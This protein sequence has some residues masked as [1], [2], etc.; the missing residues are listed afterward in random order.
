MNFSQPSATPTTGYDEDANHRQLFGWQLTTVRLIWGTFAVITVGLFLT[1]IPYRFNE[2]QVLCDQDIPCRNLQI[3]PQHEPL[4][5]DSGLSLNFYAGTI[6]I[7]ETA[8]FV[9][10]TAVALVIVWRKSDDWFIFLISLMLLIAPGGLT[11]MFGALVDHVPELDWLKGFWTS[12]A[13]S[14]GFFMIFALPDGRFVPRWSWKVCVAWA[15]YAMLLIPSVVPRFSTLADIL[16]F[17]MIFFGILSQV[18]RYKRIS[19]S[20]LQQQTKWI[21]YGFVISV[22]GI[23]LYQMVTQFFKMGAN[24]QW[25]PLYDL[26]AYP[27]RAISVFSFLVAVG[28]SVLRYRL[29]EIDILINRTLIYSI[30]TGVLSLVYLGIIAFFQLT[31][32]NLINLSNEIAAVAS[33]LVIITLFQPVRQQVQTAVDRR[34]YRRKYDTAQTLAAFSATLRD[35]VNLTDLLQAISDVIQETMQPAHLTVWLRHQVDRPGPEPFVSQTT[36]ATIAPDDPLLSHCQ[37]ANAT[38]VL[39][40]LTFQSPALRM[41]KT[42]ATTILVPIIN[43]GELISIVAL[44]PRLS[45]QAYTFDDRKLL[46]ELAIQVAPAIR[47]A[48]LVHLEQESHTAQQIQLNLLPH[49]IPQPANWHIDTYYQPART[50]GG[51]YYDF[52]ELPDG[53]LGF[54]IA[55]ATGKGMAAALLMATSRSILRAAGRRLINPGAVLAEANNLI[56]A[57]I[58]EAMFVTCFYAILNPANGELRF[59][60][61]GHNLPYRWASSKVATLRATGLPLGLMP[62]RA[63]QEHRTILAPGDTLLFYTDGL[64]EAH[65]R[66]HQ[67]FGPNR[68]QT[69]LAHVSDGRTL[70]PHLVDAFTSFARPDLAQ[71][72]DMTLVTFTHLRNDSDHPQSEFI[73]EEPT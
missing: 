6:T 57:D 3:S 45:G 43:Q 71:F 18:Y 29:W 36:S 56:C 19:T 41:M 2:L 22:L 1:A 59:A 60:N 70:I 4:L 23:G 17:S 32:S 54:M 37:Q 35:Q 8:V 40:R 10:F 66:D 72:D 51:D 28:I 21:M 5:A 15:I 24:S 65:N 49:V 62:A 64:V 69:L 58:P 46:Y 33:I 67:M 53:R 11:W 20:I 14:T 47:V 63:Y 55:D 27:M 44:G 61:A 68:L 52:L 34:F 39:D 9:V 25:H 30:L 12:T 50:V 73:Q 13:A 26:I 42:A 38:I 31:I 48:Q 16:F 7:V